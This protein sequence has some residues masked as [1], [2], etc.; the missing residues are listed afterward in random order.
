MFIFPFN[1]LS[2]GFSD[3]SLLAAS[4]LDFVIGF[5]KVLGFPGCF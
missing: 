2:V 4:A 5:R 1:D 3:V